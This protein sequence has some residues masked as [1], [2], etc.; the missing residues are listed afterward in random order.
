MFRDLKDFKDEVQSAINELKSVPKA[1][2]VNEIFFPG[3]QSH[4]KRKKN[5]E[6]GEITVIDKL[7]EELER[8]L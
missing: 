1:K 3:E 5:L 7:M 6:I 2:G 4:L 8:L